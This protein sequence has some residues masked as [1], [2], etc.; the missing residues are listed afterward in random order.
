MNRF[1]TWLLAAFLAVFLWTTPASTAAC[2]ARESL[3]GYL[4]ERFAE[5]PQAV[6]LILDQRI[7]ELFVSA[8]GTW[9]IVLTDQRGIACLVM[10]GDGWD[11]VPA[12]PAPEF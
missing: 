6:G 9:S 8:R 3:V 10:A 7:M 4:A 12:A 1:P 2:M 5:Q 11:Q